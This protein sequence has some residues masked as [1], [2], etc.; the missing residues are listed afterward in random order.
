MANRSLLYV[1]DKQKY[2]TLSE[3]IYQIPAFWQ[4]LWSE[5][6]IK[7]G[8]SHWRDIFSEDSEYIEEYLSQNISS[9]HSY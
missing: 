7:H 6:E 9:S 2:Q 4:C 3:S 5:K 1:F 8:I